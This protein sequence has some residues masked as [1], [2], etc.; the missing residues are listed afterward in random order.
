MSHAPRWRD[1]MVYTR[2]SIDTL[3][4]SDPVVTGYKTAI[5]TMKQRSQTNANDPLGWISQANIHGSPTSPA[6][7][8]WN[9]CQHGT[10][11]FLSWHRMFIWY[12]ESIVRSFSGVADWALPYWDWTNYRA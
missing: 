7:P 3:S 6:Q 10:Y 8:L 12:F 1:T 11:F 2:Q 9:G 5:T 4:S